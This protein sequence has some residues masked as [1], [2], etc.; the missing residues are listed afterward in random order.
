M[1]HSIIRADIAQPGAKGHAVIGPGNVI[2]GIFAT[3]QEAHDKA[4]SLEPA[5]KPAKHRRRVTRVDVHGNVYTAVTADR[6]DGYDRDNLGESP[7]Y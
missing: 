4:K 1:L 7:D 5:P 2:V 6:I 3:W